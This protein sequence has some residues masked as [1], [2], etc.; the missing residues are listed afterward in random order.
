MFRLPPRITLTLPLFPYTSI[1]R[2]PLRGDR[3]SWFA[4]RS[5]SNSVR[6]APLRQGGAGER[7]GIHERRGVADRPGRPRRQA[8]H[9]GARAVA[10][11]GRSEEHTSEFQ[12]LM[13]N[14]Y[15]VFF[16]KKKKQTQHED[17]HQ[18]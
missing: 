4:D 15:A 13:R 11:A 9:R 17:T 7:E 16:L 18:E 8:R 14:S 10:G 1:F 2:S 6:G 5:F 3:R 12:S